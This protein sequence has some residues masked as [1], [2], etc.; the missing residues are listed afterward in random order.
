MKNFLSAITVIAI[1][2]LAANNVTA[3]DTNNVTALQQSGNTNSTRSMVTDAKPDGTIIVN[4][5]ALKNFKRSFKN[6]SDIKWVKNQYGFTAR[7]TLNDISNVIYYDKN[8][9]WQASLKTYNEDKFNRKLRA[10][11]KSKYFDYKIT[12]VQE[13][14]NTDTNGIPTYIIHIEDEK[15]FMLVRVSDGNMDVY[16]KYNRS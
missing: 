12:Q 16:E 9:N 1:S 14:E 13:I 4:A 5:K 8:G 3:Q 2:V 10:I 11:V 15:S 6:V 7:F